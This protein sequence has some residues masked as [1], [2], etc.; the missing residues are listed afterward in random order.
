MKKFNV[1]ID[2]NKGGNIY[3]PYNK[4]IKRCGFDGGGQMNPL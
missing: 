4:S 3:W 1:N 2:K